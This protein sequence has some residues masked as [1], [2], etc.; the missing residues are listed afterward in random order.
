MVAIGGATLR[1][2]GVDVNPITR[3]RIICQQLYKRVLAV[4][5]TV[6]LY[7]RSGGWL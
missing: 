6:G 3:E 2:I 1:P 5:A 4:L 7:E